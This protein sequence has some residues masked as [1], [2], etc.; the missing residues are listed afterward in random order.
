[1]PPIKAMAAGCKPSSGSS[2]KITSGNIS[3]GK[4][5]SVTKAKKRREPS[6]VR[7]APKVLSVSLGL[8]PQQHFSVSLLDLKAVED[9]QDSADMLGRST[10]TA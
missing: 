1:M 6:D 3:E 5:S 10:Q 4:L 9:R 2:N 7:C 8:P